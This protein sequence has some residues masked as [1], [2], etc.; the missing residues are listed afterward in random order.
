MDPIQLLNWVWLTQAVNEIQS[1]NQFVNR[2]VF[3]NRNALPTETIEITSIYGDRQM[4]P[5]VRKDG[6][7]LLVSGTHKGVQNI[8]APN[9]RT[10]MPFTPSE[11]LWGQMPRGIMGAVSQEAILDL[12]A[13]HILRDLQYMADMYTNTEEWMACMAL[14]GQ[15]SYS[16]TDQETFTVTYPRPSGH[17]VTLDTFWDD[18]TP[19]NIFLE[20]TFTNAKK[21]IADAAGLGVTDVILG[22]EAAKYFRR[23]L[24]KGEVKT[25]D[26]E[27][28][29]SGEAT[30]NNQYQDDGAIKIGTF[31]NVTVWEYSRQI[32]V[33][34]T[35][36]DLIRPKY[37][38]FIANSPFA[39]NTMEFGAITDIH[40]M[41]AGNI[42]LERFSK[43]WLEN[44]PSSLMCLM[45]SRPFPVMRKAGSTASFKVISG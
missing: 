26:I 27:R 25:M 41:Q 6:E 34:G 45:A 35:P 38:E 5:F 2:L 13:Q 17:N 33:N 28:I 15:I 16:V 23:L 10:K 40:A 4:A 21:L 3:G 31:C 36:V 14:R 18:A 8:T 32:S 43:S 22:A 39:G 7:A 37:A 29:Q 19:S 20:E 11:L 42:Q 12:A 1:P 30:F 24:A 9:M 44:D